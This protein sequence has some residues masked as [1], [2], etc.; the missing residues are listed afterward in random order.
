M[1]SNPTAQQKTLQLSLNFKIKD[2]PSFE[3][4]VSHLLERKEYN[5]ILYYVEADADLLPFSQLNLP[6]THF[7]RQFFEAVVK[8]R[9][10]AVSLFIKYD[11]TSAPYLSISFVS[12]ET[13]L[14]FYIRKEKIFQESTAA[15]HSGFSRDYRTHLEKLELIPLEYV[16]K[17][18]K[19]SNN[20]G[21]IRTNVTLESKKE[22]PVGFKVLGLAIEG[23]LTVRFQGCIDA[24]TNE[25]GGPSRSVYKFDEKH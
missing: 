11:N 4:L 3:K 5:P 25:L 19:A 9:E 8:N 14:E 15:R 16:I 24:P 13:R 10:F 2:I 18:S 21:K 1:S 17:S 6:A 20:K 22:L 23:Y 12:E 7:D